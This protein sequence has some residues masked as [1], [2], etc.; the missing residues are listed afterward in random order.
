MWRYLRDIQKSAEKNYMA[1]LYSKYLRYYDA[2]VEIFWVFQ[3]N[4]FLYKLYQLFLLGAIYI[5][6]EFTN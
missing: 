5:Q 3:S 1:S 6:E 4:Y 2:S